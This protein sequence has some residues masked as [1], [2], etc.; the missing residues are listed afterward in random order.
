MI[1]NDNST[2]KDYYLYISSHF[3]LVP[4]FLSIYCE[5]YDVLWMTTII[6]LTS[7]L[8]YGNIYNRIYYY[9]DTLCVKIIFLYI[10]F[11]LIIYSILEKK[12]IVFILSIMIS[13]LFIFIIN[14]FIYIFVDPYLSI[15]IHMLVHFYSIVGLIY[16][17]HIDYDF[18]TLF[19]LIFVIQKS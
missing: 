17:L 15:V 12:E 4:L 11:S 6:L 7:L 18:N 1:Y 9:I 13:I 5:R 3:F 8:N 10:L 2:K 14:Y 19:N 16:L